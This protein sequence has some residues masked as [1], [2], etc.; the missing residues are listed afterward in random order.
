ME[1]MLL[2]SVGFLDGTA[3]KVMTPDH[4]RGLDLPVSIRLIRCMFMVMLMVK[5]DLHLTWLVSPFCLMWECE[6]G[7]DRVR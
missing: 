1:G 2:T 4:G 3:V 5:E 7:G 6:P